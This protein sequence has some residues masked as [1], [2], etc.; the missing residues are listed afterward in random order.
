MVKPL[1]TTG[2]HVAISFEVNFN[3]DPSCPNVTNL[4][5]P[6]VFNQPGDTMSSRDKLNA[7]HLCG[8]IGLAAATGSW[9][10]GVLVAAALI[11]TSI[12]T[13]QIRG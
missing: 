5:Y 6:H 4:A 1:A 7:V 10:L 9:V 2:I 11:W 3:P 8:S 13:G 12:A